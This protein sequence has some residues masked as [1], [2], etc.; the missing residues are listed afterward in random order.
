MSALFCS[1]ATDRPQKIPPRTYTLLTFP[2]GAEESY[3]VWNMHPAMQPDGAQSV[4]PDDRSGLIWPDTVGLGHLSACIHW[5]AGGYREIRDRFV[6]D[7]LGLM[8]GPDSTATDH[9][10]PS[11]GQ[12]FFT[13]HH[14]IVVR[15]NWPL[16]LLVYHDDSVPRHVT[17]AQFKLTIHPL[18][19]LPSG[20]A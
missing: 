9:R 16:G 15:P 4:F 20:G 3:D 6:R 19:P 12:Q 13:K 14:E 18:A 1:L 5:E 17:Y 2:Y 7:P 8:G 11:L 10:A